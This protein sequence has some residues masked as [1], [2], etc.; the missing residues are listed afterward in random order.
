MEPQCAFKSAQAWLVFLIIQPVIERMLKTYGHHFSFRRPP[1]DS[2]L[3]L[4]SADSWDAFDINWVNRREHIHVGPRCAF[5]SLAW[6]A[7]KLGGMRL[8]AC[9]WHCVWARWLRNRNT[10][11]TIAMANM[12]ID[13]VARSYPGTFS[14]DPDN[15]PRIAAQ[16]HLFRCSLSTDL[17]VE[18]AIELLLRV[19][20]AVGVN[21]QWTCEAA[22]A[23][24]LIYAEISIRV[25]DDLAVGL[26]R[27]A[28]AQTHALI[29]NREGPNSASQL[30][31]ALAFK[32][33]LL[34]IHQGSPLRSTLIPAMS[35]MV[36][37]WLRSSPPSQ[38]SLVARRVF[39]DVMSYLESRAWN[40]EDWRLYPGII[41]VAKLAGHIS[42]LW[43]EYVRERYMGD[44]SAR[45]GVLQ[46][47]LA[48]L[49]LGSHGLDARGFADAISTRSGSIRSADG[50]C[51][52]RPAPDAD[53]N[54]GTVDD[55]HVVTPW[56]LSHAVRASQEYGQ[57]H[58]CIEVHGD[59]QADAT[60][61]QID[62]NCPASPSG[63]PV[64]PASLQG[65]TTSPEPLV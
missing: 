19:A 8:R 54:P 4:K 10:R 58:L 48:M 6:I 17:P 9:I 37:Q 43:P 20:P 63:S 30:N 11:A 57:S 45:T 14:L 46:D 7:K 42:E 24:L 34:I 28:E 53:A 36:L 65:N 1:H 32:Y 51:S 27:L 31:A 3:L 61:I 21:S 62:V 25:S 15:P 64:P 16:A 59:A 40:G 29:T 2:A 38:V 26:F 47:L 50:V 22:R 44:P 23:V 55:A 49:P 18:T 52:T 41:L 35:G 12:D 33:I 39:E 56:P 5:Q 60:A 13:P